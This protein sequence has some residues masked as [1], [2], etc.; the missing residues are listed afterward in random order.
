VHPC[1]CLLL[2]SNIESSLGCPT[3][4][5]TPTEST[6]V[7]PSQLTARLQKS[8]TASFCCCSHDFLPARTE[9]SSDAN[10]QGSSSSNRRLPVPTV[11]AE[12]GSTKLAVGKRRSNVRAGLPVSSHAVLTVGLYGAGSVNFELS[13]E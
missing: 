8:S 7:G 6:R 2:V 4:T 10:Q 12:H 3:P 5:P 1:R 9:L 11:D 13:M